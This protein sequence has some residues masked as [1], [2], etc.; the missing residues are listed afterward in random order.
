MQVDDVNN[1]A[2]VQQDVTTLLRARHHLAGPV[3][4]S[5]GQQNGGRNPARGLGGGFGSGNGTPARG[6]GSGGNPNSGQQTSGG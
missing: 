3:P 1:V 4:S 5:Q 2:Q 6:F